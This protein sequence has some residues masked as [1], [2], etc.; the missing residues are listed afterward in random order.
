MPHPMANILTTFTLL[1]LVHHATAGLLSFQKRQSNGNSGVFVPA[2]IN[3]P[4]QYA[5][6]GKYLMP[7]QMSNGSNAQ[8][9]NFTIST[10][11]G[12]TFVGGDS[13]STCSGVN[14]YNQNL[15][16][17]AQ[18]LSNTPDTTDFLAQSTSGTVIKELCSIKTQN[19]SQWKYPNQTVVVINQ[20][21]PN[22]GVPIVGS[23]TG[24]S[25]IVGLG[26]NAGQSSGNSSSFQPGFADTI[27]AQWLTNNPTA[28]NF[29]FG[30]NLKAPTGVAQNDV[31]GSLSLTDGGNLDWLQPDPSKYDASQVQWKT[32]SG[33]VATGTS[34]NTASSQEWEVSLDG[35]VFVS[36]GNKIQN[37]EGVVAQV[38]PMYPN[39]YLPLSE[40][41]LIHAAI[42]GSAQAANLSTLGSE[43]TAWT[44]PCN[45]QFSFGFVVGSQTF[46]LDPNSLLINRGNGVCSSAIE[47]WTSSSQQNY[48]LG[49]RFISA[50]Y[51]IFEVGRD[52]SQ[53]VGF[54][55]RA[56]PSKSSKTGAIVGGVLGGIGGAIILAALIFLF[57]RYRRNRIANTPGQY[58]G[59]I[60]DKPEGSNGIV[61]FTL[62]MGTAGAA[63]T[64][65]TGSATSPTTTHFSTGLVSPVT[66][67]ALAADNSPFAHPDHHEILPPA[68]DDSE[69]SYGAGSSSGS[70]NGARGAA[71][72]GD[73]KTSH[74]GDG[75]GGGG[76]RMPEPEAQYATVRDSVQSAGSQPTPTSPSSV[77]RD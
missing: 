35:F 32:V 2:T 17:T 65:A 46:T 38:E 77:G 30:M 11:S 49:A 45:S 60:F 42:P 6:T 7:V 23:N 44:V 70:R 16:S 21:Q 57:V 31:S 72:L 43:S 74:L 63:A 14:L 75:S 13:C 64:T 48:L 41:T 73:R 19:G 3:L 62:G 18:P 51:L 56:T 61:P 71:P 33:G 66:S 26:T 36:G 10:G 5:S 4:L 50:V 27:Y 29:T 22:G 8:N 47:G 9:F 59:H 54:A 39:L 40:A 76:V 15:S 67:D 20:Q 53:T 69:V 28:L 68:Y 25:G 1:S 34:P 55:P 12:L 58:D 24:V 37:S 52:G